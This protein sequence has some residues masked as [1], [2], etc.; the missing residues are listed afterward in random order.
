MADTRLIVDHL[1][2]DYKGPF[3]FNGLIRLINAFLKERGFDLRHDKDFEMNTKKGKQ[4]EWQISP[5]KRVSDYVNFL[6]KIRILAQDMGKI[7]VVKDKKKVKVD[8]GRII[9]TIDGWIAFDYFHKWDE[10]PFLMFLRSL[11][12]RFIYK[13]YTERFEQRFSYDMKQLY[14]RIEQFLNMYKQYKVV[15]IEPH[16][17]H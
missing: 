3:E 16:F 7:E 12:D 4:M 5:W 8:N 9:M 10:R 1:R 2:L 15:T 13:V 11:Y 14:D 17:S 6:P